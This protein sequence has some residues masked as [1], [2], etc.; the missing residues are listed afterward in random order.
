MW[1]KWYAGNLYCY[2]EVINCPADEILDVSSSVTQ[3]LCPGILCT[4][5]AGA[6]CGATWWYEDQPT[7]V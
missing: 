5:H 4:V 7:P 1:I 2:C 6:T 3:H